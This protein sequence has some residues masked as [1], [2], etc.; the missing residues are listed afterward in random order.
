MVQ[1]D[2]RRVRS[3]H[4]K[5]P[6]AD[7]VRKGAILVE[8]ALRMASLP[9]GEGSRVVFVRSLNLGRFHSDGSSA[10]VALLIQQ[11][12]SRLSSHLIHGSDLNAALA[13]AVYFNDPV[14]PI[15]ILTRYLARGQP[16]DGWFW[17]LAV[18]GWRKGQSVTE[19]LRRLLFSLLPIECAQVA[20]LALI[21]VLEAEGALDAILSGLRPQE[22]TVLLQVMAG[23]P[24]SVAGQDVPG[25]G[26]E[27]TVSVPRSW[28]H[29]LAR[30]A[31][32]WPLDDPRMVWLAVLSLADG[33]PTRLTSPDILLRAQQLV[34]SIQAR[35][36]TLTQLQ[37]KQPSLPKGQRVETDVVPSENPAPL[38]QQERGVASDTASREIGPSSS[39][40]RPILGT[41]NIE[42]TRGST[43]PPVHNIEETRRGTG[44][45]VHE[46]ELPDQDTGSSP[47]SRIQEGLWTSRFAGLYYLLPVLARLGL[48]SWLE[49]HPFAITHNFCHELLRSIA[50]RL[51]AAEDDSALLPIAPPDH[52]NDKEAGSEP[53]SFIMPRSWL[54]G[55]A[56][57]KQ[58][59]LHRID[60]RRHVRALRD[61]SGRLILSLWRSPAPTGVRMFTGHIGLA[62]GPALPAQSDFQLALET[63]MSAAELWCSQFA[64]TGMADLVRLPGKL[65]VTRTHLDAYFSLSQMDIRVRRAGLD[66]N[67]GWLPWFGRVVSYWYREEEQHDAS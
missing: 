27:F 65:L 14:E 26:R 64:Q 63:W 34:S 59:T 51:G 7:L 23:E 25:A 13:S 29:I 66:I 48:P 10:G 55:I 30:W 1:L 47:L 42:E 17:P 50:L 4:L 3:L 58:M 49:E 33:R 11:E 46:D 39:A 15:L 21:K 57:E 41:S 9:G 53:W 54:G 60:G 44:L 52:D 24:P 2:T 8:D 56:A 6:R 20:V 38:L 45:F 43:E 67:P 61:A 36:V 32:Q 22:G 62:R 19:S 18:P 16:A 12:L 28:Q 37:Q 5:A 35:T 31:V 40:R